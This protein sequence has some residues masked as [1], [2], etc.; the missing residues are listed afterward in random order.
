MKKVCVL[1]GMLA[2]LLA[3]PIGAWAEHGH[4]GP[5]RHRRQWDRSYDRFW[6]WHKGG[7]RQ[8]PRYYGPRYVCYPP[9]PYYPVVYEGYPPY[10]WR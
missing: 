3:G 1:V 2:V 8:P 4:K 10:Y 5:D 7:W 6:G 9:V